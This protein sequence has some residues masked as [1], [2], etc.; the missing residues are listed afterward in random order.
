V[1][2]ARSDEQAAYFGISRDAAVQLGAEAKAFTAR[3]LAKPFTIYTRWRPVYGPTRYYAFVVT[4]D[5]QDL[6]ELLVRNGLAR[7][8]GTRTP[9][10]DGRDSRTYL[11]TLNAAEAAAKAAR[12]GGWRAS[13]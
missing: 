5:G 1:H 6:A 12:L 9:L 7:I 2:S 10:P 8:Y 4:A 13:P 11:A 3:A